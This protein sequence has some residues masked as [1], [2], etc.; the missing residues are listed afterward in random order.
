MFL[1]DRHKLLFCNFQVTGLVKRLNNSYNT[2]NPV[3]S[4]LVREFLR[5]LVKTLGHSDQWV[6]RQVFGALAGELIKNES[7]SPSQFAQDILTDLINLSNDKVPNVRLKVAQSLYY[8]VISIGSL[9]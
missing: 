3:D 7:M 8:C 6:R 2:K 5:H 9:N 1:W 4:S